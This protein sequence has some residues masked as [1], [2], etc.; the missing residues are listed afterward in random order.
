MSTCSHSEQVLPTHF[1][2][3][4]ADLLWKHLVMVNIVNLVGLRITWETNLWRVHKRFLDWV[5]FENVHLNCRQHHPR[6]WGLELKK[7]RK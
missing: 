1:A 4:D 2:A 7:R 3:L 6:G 5:N